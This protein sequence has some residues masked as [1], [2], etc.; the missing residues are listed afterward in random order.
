MCVC[1]YVYIV[2]YY[3]AIKKSEKNEVLFNNMDG[4]RGFILSELSDRQRHIT[5]DFTY[6]LNLKITTKN[7]KQKQ[8]QIWR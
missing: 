7:T 4:P 1:V 5:Y 8:T 6:I 3:S 2:E